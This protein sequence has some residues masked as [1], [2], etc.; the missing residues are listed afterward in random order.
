MIRTLTTDFRSMEEAFERL[1]N[2]APRRVERPANYIPIDVIE[3]AN[4]LV[5]KAALPG[6]APDQIS[7]K[8][9]ENVLTISGQTTEEILSEGDRLHRRELSFGS[10]VRSVRLPDNVNQEAIDAEFKSGIL[11]LTIPKVEEEKPKSIN[12]EVRAVT[13]TPTEN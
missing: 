11:T 3:R 1:L 8:V 4:A 2:P 6:F 7:V 5:I 12:V 10:Y 13:P 9:E